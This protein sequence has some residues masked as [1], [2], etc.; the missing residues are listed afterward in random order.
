M[1]MT[2]DMKLNRTSKYCVAGNKMRERGARVHDERSILEKVFV[3]QNALEWRRII[4][5]VC[6]VIS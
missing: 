3:R 2:M 5:R 4:I 1:T 6:D